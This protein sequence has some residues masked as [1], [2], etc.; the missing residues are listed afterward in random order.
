MNH[1][2]IFEFLSQVSFDYGKIN[3]TIVSVTS[4]RRN[5]T[6]HGKRDV[7]VTFQVTRELYVNNFLIF[8]F[9]DL[10]YGKI[11]TKIDLVSLYFVLVK[12]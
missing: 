3:T 4:I 2:I 1:F 9:P 5:K 11:N 8:E 6:G 12:I 7:T 10:I